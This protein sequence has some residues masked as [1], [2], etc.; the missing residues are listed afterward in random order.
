[1]Q[2]PRDD[3]PFITLSISELRA[4]GHQNEMDWVCLLFATSA[5]DL[6]KFIDEESFPSDFEKPLSP[7]YMFLPV[8]I[9]KW[10]IEQVRDGL[11]KLMQRVLD[12]EKRVASGDINALKGA[13][14]RLFEVGMEHLKLRNRWLFAKELAA[15]LTKCFNEI[16]I[17]GNSNTSKANYSKTLRDRVET[18]IALSEMLKHDLETIPSKVQTQHQMASIPNYF[19]L[20]E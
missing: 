4:E 15:N 16:A 12:G 3:L 20:L 5:I 6:N 9:L 2:T 11:M 7:D 18:Q 19:F 1:L 13:K 10:Q 8:R 14:T 17:S